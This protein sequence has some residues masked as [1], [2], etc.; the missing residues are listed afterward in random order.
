M[1]AENGAGVKF[2]PGG[3]LD[4]SLIHAETTISIRP[5]QCSLEDSTG[6]VCHVVVRFR[7]HVAAT[8]F[9]SKVLVPPRVER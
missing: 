1:T 4:S 7:Y 5:S 9:E 2:H 8:N 3:D 6:S